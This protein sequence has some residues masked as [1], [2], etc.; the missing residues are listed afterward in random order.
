MGL[1]LELLTPKGHTRVSFARALARRVK[2]R[3]EFGFKYFSE[4][5][6]PDGRPLC[7]LSLATRVVE[8]GGRVLAWVM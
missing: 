5:T 4:G 3:V 6:L 7:R 1:E 8:R 2:G